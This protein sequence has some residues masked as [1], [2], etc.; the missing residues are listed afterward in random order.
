MRKVEVYC[1][2]YQEADGYTYIEWY[3]FKEIPKVI[4]DD[5]YLIEGFMVETYDGSNIYLKAL[6]NGKVNR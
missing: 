6:K 2:V 3:L 4:R 1:G 5:A